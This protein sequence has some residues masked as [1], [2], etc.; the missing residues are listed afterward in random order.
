MSPKMKTWKRK[1]LFSVKGNSQQKIS[2]IKLM[3]VQKKNMILSVWNIF[4]VVL[5]KVSHTQQSS[6]LENQ[7]KQ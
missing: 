4:S 5:G 1:L 7:S 3:E 2:Q 6:L